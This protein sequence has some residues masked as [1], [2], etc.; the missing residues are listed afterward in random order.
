[1]AGRGSPLPGAEPSHSISPPAPERLC[2]P[3][4]RT[5]RPGEGGRS[6]AAMAL[7]A[8]P[9]SAV[10][11]AAVFVGGAVSSPLVAPGEC[12]VGAGAPGAE[13]VPGSAEG[14]EGVGTA[15]L[16]RSEEPAFSHS[17]GILALNNWLSRG[18][19]GR[20]RCVAT[21][22]VP[23]LPPAPLPP[24]LPGAS[25]E[26]LCPPAL[27]YAG[28]RDQGFLGGASFTAARLGTPRTPFPPPLSSKAPGAE[29]RDREH[30]VR[31]RRLLL[32]F[33][34]LKIS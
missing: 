10:L 19:L 30:R 20:A 8:L 9:G 3:E 24:S 29:D 1:M 28:R 2:L 11:A 15:A 27:S 17:L 13:S 7:R 14:S 21:A 25:A 31:C 4:R 22:L 6:D 33:K 32:P 23:P 26:G 12:P 5:R 34:Y 18:G 16:R